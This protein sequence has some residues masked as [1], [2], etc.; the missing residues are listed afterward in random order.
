MRPAQYRRLVE[1]RPATAEGAFLTSDELT[2]ALKAHTHDGAP[3]PAITYV[4]GLDLGVSKDWCA[5][6]IGHVDAGT[7]FTVD[8]VR[9]YRPSPGKRISLVNIEEDVIRIA[10]SYRLSSLKIDLVAGRRN[11]RSACAVRASLHHS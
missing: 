2:D 9:F 1:N 3:N 11:L 6:T 7:R 8:L 4:G 10:K 5:L